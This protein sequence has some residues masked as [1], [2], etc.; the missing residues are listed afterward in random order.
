MKCLQLSVK[1]QYFDHYSRACEVWLAK[2][3]KAEYHVV[4]E[5]RGAATLASAV[6]GERPPPIL[7]PPEIPAPANR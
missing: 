2:N 6:L 1:V 7:L 5:L 4:D 3:Y